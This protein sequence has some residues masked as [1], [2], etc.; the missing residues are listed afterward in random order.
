[1]SLNLFLA[2]LYSQYGSNHGEDMDTRFLYEKYYFMILKKCFNYFLQGIQNQDVENKV[3]KAAI[4]YLG[5]SQVF[6]KF[7]RGISS[8]IFF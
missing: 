7:L 2:I 3:I 5:P 8:L 1:M 4:L 6:P